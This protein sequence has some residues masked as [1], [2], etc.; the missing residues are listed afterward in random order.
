MTLNQICLKKELNHVVPFSDTISLIHDQ[1]LAPPLL[2]G[3]ETMENHDSG[4]DSDGER[5]TPINN[6]CIRLHALS[7]SIAGLSMFYG[8]PAMGKVA[9]M[10]TRCEQLLVTL[11]LARQDMRWKVYQAAFAV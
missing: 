2:Q 6:L 1:G 3:L 11:C 4:F 10:A 5:R 8:W 9:G 7:L